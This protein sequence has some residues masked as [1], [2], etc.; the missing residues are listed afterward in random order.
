MATRVPRMNRKLIV[1][2]SFVLVSIGMVGCDSADVAETAGQTETGVA[3]QSEDGTEIDVESGDLAPVRFAY[4]S[5]LWGAPLILAEIQDMWSAEGLDVTSRRFSAGKDVRDA[6]LAGSADAGSL[7]ATPFIAS[8]ASGQLVAVAAAGYLGDTVW[9]VAGAES[10]IESVTDLAGK[11]VAAREGS[12]TELIFT[13]KVLPAHG[14]SEED[15]NMLNV[16][17]DE[18]VSA[19]S[20]GNVDAFVGLEPYISIA[21]TEGIGT[22]VESFAEYDQLPN[23]FAFDRSFVEEHEETVVATVRSYMRTTEGIEKDFD[24]ALAV[25]HED[26]SASGLE[27]SQDALGSAL[28]RVDVNPVLSEDFRDYLQSQAEAL[29]AEGNIES[30]PDWD[31]VLRLDIQEKAMTDYWAANSE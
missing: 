13:T 10:G 7:G 9:L 2:I 14:M 8:A 6:V 15:V 4:Q 1:M 18:H 22:L 29:L 16:G 5:S 17:F 26:F 24:S 31:D 20:S 27:I 21:T 19:L 28:E 3:Q 30:I 25:L 12:I 23:V 11:N